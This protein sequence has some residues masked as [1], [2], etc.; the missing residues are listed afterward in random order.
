MRCLFWLNVFLFGLLIPTWGQQPEQIQFLEGHEAPARTVSYSPDGKTVISGSADGSVRIWDRGTGTLIRTIKRH[1]GPVLSMAVSPDGTQFATGGLDHQIQVE[2]LPTI[3]PL[4]SLATVPNVPTE[5]VISSDGKRLL[6]GDISNI[7][8]LWSLETKANV[9]DYG[10]STK[11]ITGAAFLPKAQQIAA[12]SGDGYL[13]GWIEKDA[14]SIGAIYTTP[15]SAI[16]V[17]PEE[18]QIA[19]AGQDGLLRLIAWPPTT[20][21]MLTGHSDQ[22][23]EVTMSADGKLIVSGGNDAKINQYTSEA[24]KPIKT[25]KGQDGPVTA[26][27]L[28]ADSA[29]I[30]TGSNKGT[31]RVWKTEDSS[32]L[33]TLATAHAGSV[34]GAAFHPKLAQLATVGSDGV[35]QVWTLGP[36]PKDPQAKKPPKD[37]LELVALKQFKAH[38]GVATNVVF[39]S[40]GKFLFSAGVDKTV[41]QWDAQTG[42]LLGTFT[43]STNQ[44]NDVAVTADGKTLVAGA[45]DSK[46]YVWTIPA[47][48]DSA[49]PAQTALLKTYAHTAAIHTVA[50]TDDGGMIAAAGDDRIIRVWETA[51]DTER[52]RFVGHTSTVRAI[53]FSEDGKRLVS[54]GADQTLR[55]WTPSVLAAVPAH[56]EGILDVKFSPDGTQ[57]FTT[58]ADK[59]ARQ[60]AATDL[61]PVRTFTGSPEPIRVMALSDT[62]EFFAA[63]AE[64]GVLRFWNTKTEQPLTTLKIVGKISDV[65]I[66]DQGRKLIVTAGENL[67]QNYGIKSQDNKLQFTLVNEFQGHTA[68]V[69]HL[70]LASDG[71]TLI[72][73]SPDRT[74]KHWYAASSSPR[75]TLSGP[76]KAVYALAF[77][78]AGDR[79][80]SGNGDHHVRVWEPLSGQEVFTLK[81]HTSQVFAL[82][83]H[84]K[85]NQLA[86]GGRD[87]AVRLW[88]METGTA[89]EPLASDDPQSVYSLAYAPDGKWLA[90]AGTDPAWTAVSLVKPK[91]G[92]DPAK[93]ILGAGHNETIQCLAYNKAGTRMASVDYSGKLIIWSA[94]NGQLLYHQQLPSL[95][96]YQLAYAPDGVELSVA[97]KDPRVLRVVIPSYAR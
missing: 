10:G 94:S 53:A 84:P 31:I 49:K 97:S 91:E 88:N 34:T 68:A 14:K 29:W 38:Q 15:L 61:K 4:A 48:P 24:A 11:P 18:N 80:A 43:G 27:A 86:S 33:F 56:K 63:A 60:F 65:L 75:F 36:K 54:A 66:G 85:E 47:N 12:A 81:G 69:T 58:G 73:T 40:D 2:D 6:T 22:I 62:G 46:V 23:A 90:A 87:D 26:L 35:L 79:L 41:K 28:N 82:A 39:S 93:P 59:T 32:Q 9:R 19:G 30:A 64:E 71:R 16:A 44:L 74:V 95:T 8:R 50:V 1:T 21:K 13:R 72:S 77:N 51:T 25:L 92:E 78:P 37:A 20:P 96:A 76:T 45:S 7:V 42:L 70:A 57:I 3:H 17:H 89:M 52:E 67:I 5:L 55:D 83:F